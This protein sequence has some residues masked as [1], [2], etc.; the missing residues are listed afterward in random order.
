MT[1]FYKSIMRIIR[2]VLLVIWAV[3]V[4]SMVNTVNTS[5]LNRQN[6]LVMMRA[7]GMTRRQL[8]GTVLLESALFCG[9]STVCGLIVSII[10]YFCGVAF[11]LRPE[12]GDVDAYLRDALVQPGLIVLV[13]AAVLLINLVISVFAAIPGIR[14]LQT[15]LKQT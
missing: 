1:E 15:K 14:I 8:S 2:I 5:V 3:G 10:C 12:N 11:M 7:V 13:I 6:E 4:F 9:I